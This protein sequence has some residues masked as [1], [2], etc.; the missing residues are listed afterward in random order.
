M[1]E[2][3]E[4]VKILVVDDNKFARMSISM[5]LDSETYIFIEAADGLDG[6]KKLEENP[7]VKLIIADYYMPNMDGLAMCEE[8]RK[9]SDHKK[10]PI[11]MVTT[12]SSK[13][14]QEKGKQVGVMAWMCKPVDKQKLMHIINALNI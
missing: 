10:I 6:L 9:K 1:N 8:I 11:F 5:S 13:A 3:K 12:E 4:K 7:D 2:K 14:I